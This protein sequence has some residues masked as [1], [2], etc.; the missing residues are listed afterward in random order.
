M[1]NRL[2]ITLNKKVF[3]KKE[4]D[5]YID[6]KVIIIKTINGEKNEY[7]YERSSYSIY[8]NEYAFVVHRTDKISLMGKV[9]EC[10]SNTYKI[11]GIIE[12]YDSINWPKEFILK[13]ALPIF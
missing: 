3:S 10:S 4:Y 7:I 12:I 2:K 6:E 13:K 1:Y 5:I 8:I 9:E 11:K